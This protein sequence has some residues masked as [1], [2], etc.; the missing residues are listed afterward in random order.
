M[1]VSRS[2][3]PID[4]HY[5]IAIKTHLRCRCSRDL[6]KVNTVPCLTFSVKHVRAVNN[7]SPFVII[8]GLLGLPNDPYICLSICGNYSLRLEV[9][10]S[11]CNA[12]L[13][14]VG[15]A[16]TDAD[17]H[18]YYLAAVFRTKRT[19]ICILLLSD[20]NDINVSALRERCIGLQVCMVCLLRLSHLLY[21]SHQCRCL[22]TFTVHDRDGLTSAFRVFV[23]L[24]YHITLKGGIS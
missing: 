12:A 23:M 8:N 6:R 19:L 15:A 10:T 4:T 14:L 20:R 18:N 22:L 7:Y 9:A 3:H 21:D 13:N 5:L 24:M 11:R 2:K 17:N 1:S 16:T